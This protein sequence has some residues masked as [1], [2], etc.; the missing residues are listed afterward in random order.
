MAA[1]DS[2][3][4]KSSGVEMLY[5]RLP[6]TRSGGPPPCKRGEVDVEHVGLVH[7]ELAG[8]LRARSRS[9][10]DQVAVDLD[11]LEP[12]AALEEGQGERPAPRADLDDAFAGLRVDRRDDS[13]E[14]ARVMQEMLAEALARANHPGVPPPAPRRSASRIASNRLPGS[15]RP[16]PARS[17]AVP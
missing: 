5:G 2:S 10:R 4:W 9:S 15:A 16:V 7:D 13:R 8:A 12:L 11:D 14:D 1:R 3:R 6:Q 17:S